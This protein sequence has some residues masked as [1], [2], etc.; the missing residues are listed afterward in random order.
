MAQKLRYAIMNCTEMDA[1]YKTT[2][3]EVAG[4]GFPVIQPSL[5]LGED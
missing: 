1:D 2:E 5:G 3:I 4:W